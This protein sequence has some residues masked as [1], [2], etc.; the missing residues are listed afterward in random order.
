MQVDDRDCI[1][2]YGLPGDVLTRVIAMVCRRYI[3]LYDAQASSRHAPC[4]MSPPPAQG[5]ATCDTQPRHRHASEL[6][7][8]SNVSTW[9][10]RHAWLET[11]PDVSTRAT[12][13]GGHAWKVGMQS[14]H[15]KRMRANVALG[16]GLSTSPWRQL[17]V[18]F[19]TLVRCICRVPGMRT[20]QVAN[21]RLPTCAAPER[22][23]SY[24]I[25]HAMWY[26]P[27][28]TFEGCTVSAENCKISLEAR[29]RRSPG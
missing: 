11:G 27:I 13:L 23:P 29:S 12:A 16:A 21:S 24:A 10:D 19:C 17:C 18:C 15:D 2:R 22:S 6:S 25:L 5:V 1:C 9:N 20:R 7:R 8:N 26:V 14:L 3:R 4:H 28:S